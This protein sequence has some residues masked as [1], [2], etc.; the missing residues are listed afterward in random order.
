MNDLEKIS[1]Y[2]ELSKTALTF[3]R[4]VTQ[5]QWLSVFNALKQVEGCVQFWI[6]DALA[7]RQQRWGMYDDIAEK[8]GYD[9]ETLRE[10]KQVSESVKSELR[11]P[12][13]GFHHH[14]AVESLE[15]EQQKEVLKKAADEHFSVR[16]TREEVKKIKRGGDKETPALPDKKYQIIY[17]DPP[18]IYEGSRNIADESTITNE[19]GI[20]YKGMTIEELC[21]LNIIGICQKDCLLFMW[22][23]GPKLNIAFPVIEAWGFEYCTIGFVWDK[24]KINPGSYTLSQTELCLIGRKG[25]IPEPRGSRNEKQF[26]SLERTIHSEKPE[27][28]RKRIEAMFPTQKKLE[29]FARNKAKGWDS[30]GNEI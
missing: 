2:C 23:T 1:S 5:D 17:A 29:L 27:E 13:L 3:K 8:T 26:L 30:W 4:E 20:H 6:G 28:I 22:T 7:Y 12:D 25:N 16:E 10:Y 14:K 9:K 24:Q 21:N 19:G 15:P 18:W 11:N